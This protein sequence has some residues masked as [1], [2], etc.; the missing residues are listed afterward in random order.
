MTEA[1]TPLPFRPPSRSPSQ[2]SDA[3]S[4]EWGASRCTTTSARQQRYKRRTKCK[5]RSVVVSYTNTSRCTLSSLYSSLHINMSTSYSVM[6]LPFH[7]YS[8]HTNTSTN[9]YNTVYTVYSMF[10][11]PQYTQVPVCIARRHVDQL[12]STLYT[13]LYTYVLTYITYIQI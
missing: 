13:S 1:R 9:T 12:F 3:T 5:C 8:Y 4:E 2:Q 10:Y 11:M 7:I 6:L